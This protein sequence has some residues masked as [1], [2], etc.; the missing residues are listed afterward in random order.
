MCSIKDLNCD[1]LTEHNV[2]IV[3]ISAFLYIIPS[4]LVIKLHK[5]I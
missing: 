5:S 3:N 4:I 2:Y 1:K